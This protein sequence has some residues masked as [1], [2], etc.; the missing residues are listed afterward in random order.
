[1]STIHWDLGHNS[2]K[3]NIKELKNSADIIEC[4]LN[5]R[6]KGMSLAQ[7]QPNPRIQGGINEVKNTQ[8]EHAKS[9]TILRNGKIVNNSNKGF[10]P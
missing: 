10:T 5:V 8:V 2:Q 7:P 6:E 3:Q 4:H 1:M 9:V